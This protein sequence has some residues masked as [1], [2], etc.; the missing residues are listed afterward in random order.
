V[1]G[2]G[3]PPFI[4]VAAAVA[5]AI[6]HAAGVRVRQLPITAERVLTALVANEESDTEEG[7]PHA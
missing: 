3:E 5:N 1:K 6:A 2:I 4:G 7:K